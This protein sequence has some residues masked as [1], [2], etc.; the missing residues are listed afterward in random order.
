MCACSR[1]ALLPAR[2]R[3]ETVP[4]LLQHRCYQCRRLLI[5]WLLCRSYREDVMADP[6]RYIDRTRAYY[7]SQGYDKPYRWAHFDDV[8]FDSVWTIMQAAAKIP[9]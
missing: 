6:V 4:S 9:D 2:D 1:Y 8:P 5:L 3:D 7:L